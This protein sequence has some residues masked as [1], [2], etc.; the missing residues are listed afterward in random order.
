[1]LLVYVDDVIIAGNTMSEFQ[2]INDIL[3]SSFKIKDLGQLKYFLGLEVAHSSQGISLCQRKYC[4]DLLIDLGHLASKPV[5]TPS[6][7]S[8]S[9]IQKIDREADLSHKQ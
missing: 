4:I 1:M 5:S 7:P 9:F 3:H 6:K 8:C 2:H